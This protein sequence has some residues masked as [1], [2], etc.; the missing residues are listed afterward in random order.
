MGRAGPGCEAAASGRGARRARPPPERIP[1]GAGAGHGAAP[2][3]LRPP[4]APV[5][6]PRTG[7]RPRGPTR[8]Q[9]RRC[10][11][12]R[13]GPPPRQRPRARLPARWRAAL[14]APGAAWH[15]IDWLLGATLLSVRAGSDRCVP[16]AT[17]WPPSR[18]GRALLWITR[19]T[20]NKSTNQNRIRNPGP[21]F[22]LCPPT[23]GEQ[24]PG[25]WL[26]RRS[27]GARRSA[28]PRCRAHDLAVAAQSSAPIHIRGKERE[29]RRMCFTQGADVFTLDVG[30][31]ATRLRRQRA[32]DI[33]S[34]TAAQKVRDPVRGGTQDLGRGACPWPPATS[35]PPRKA[36]ARSKGSAAPRR[37]APA[38]RASR[39]G[40][41]RRR[42]L[43]GGS[44][45]TAPS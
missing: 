11:C 37:A 44:R 17:P 23:Q 12:R 20:M 21:L 31:N 10:G 14:R 25:S 36:A 3:S 32:Q 28:T 40:A 26:W 43:T 13:A 29:C 16:G 39:Q 7:R 2:C 41:P 8:P 30:C 22:S 4:P 34:P 6:G 1:L 35:G 27:G 18:A 33:L 45:R 5:H 38:G 19:G 24:R 15:R 9:T 42:P